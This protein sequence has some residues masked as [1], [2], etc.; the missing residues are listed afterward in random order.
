MTA[1]VIAACALAVLA[2]LLLF[3]PGAAKPAPGEGRDA[4]NLQILKEQLAALD[5]EAAAGAIDVGEAAASRRDIERRVHD[6]VGAAT[7]A[8]DV[9][10][11]PS[12]RTQLWLG[13]AIP[14]FAFGVYG[15]LGNPDALRQQTVQP[16]AARGASASPDPSPDAVQAML[17]EM[18]QRM[19]SQPQGTIDAAGWAMVA[20]SYAAIQR[21]DSASRAYALAL[22][23]APTDAQLLAEQAQVM[24][25]LRGEH[26]ATATATVRGTIRIAP[27]LAGQVGPN[28]TVFVFARALGAAGERGMPLAA[29][30]YPAA[31]LPIDFSLDDATPMNG[32]SR[33]SEAGPLIVTARIS[34]TGDAMPQPGDLRGE[35]EPVYGMRDAVQVTIGAVQR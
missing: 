10:A 3:L 6:E 21:H 26:P 11:A 23:L 12:R 14:V 31:G 7:P 16:S 28:D 29:A 4:A 22:A 8:A 13:I 19:A 25:A 33:L 17:D 18:V 34:K 27:A 32:A 9:P 24:K 2:W 1:F 35:S 30:R 5:R 20:R 15:F